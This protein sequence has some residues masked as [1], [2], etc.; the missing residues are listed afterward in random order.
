MLNIA[1]S[2]EAVLEKNIFKHIPIYYYEKGLSP[3]GG[4]IHNPKGLHLN[5]VESP[6]PKDDPCQISM[7]SGQWFMR[8]RL[9]KV[10]QNFPYFATHWAP[11][12]ASPFI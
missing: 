1:Q 11:K 6:C 2:D 4:A 10:Y 7:H 12:G 3:W 9:F 8:R 5:T